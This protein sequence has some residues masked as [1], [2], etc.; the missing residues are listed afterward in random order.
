MAAGDAA[1]LPPSLSP[2]TLGAPSMASCGAQRVRPDEARAQERYA[3]RESSTYTVWPPSP[4]RAVSDSEEEAHGSRM[5]GATRRA[6]ADAPRRPHRHHRH[7]RVHRHHHR[8]HHRHPT[9]VRSTTHAS[10]SD[11]SQSAPSVGAA[12]ANA[13]SSEEE[14]GP[15]PIE[16]AVPGAAAAADARAYGPHLLPHEGAAMAAYV[17]EGKRIPR[18]GEIGWD[19]DQIQTLERAGYVMSGARHETMNAVRQRKEGQVYSAEDKRAHLR[20][21]AEERARK[22]ARVIAQFREMVDALQSA[23]P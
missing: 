21:Q 2:L 12:E 23:E 16:E 15:Q 17:R 7:H 18:R 4:L 14:I 6:E 13:S 19:A 20:H 3:I 9:R 11:L 8:R 1:P 10:Q 5:R 22:E